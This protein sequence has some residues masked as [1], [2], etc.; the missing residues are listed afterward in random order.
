MLDPFRAVVRRCELCNLEVA[1][2]TIEMFASIPAC[3][4]CRAGK[5][6]RALE[7][8]ALAVSLERFARDP[9][10]SD[11]PTVARRCSMASSSPRT[12]TEALT[13]RGP[14]LPT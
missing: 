9:R 1:A 6:D 8:W 7:R 2:E 5:L 10:G 3:H 13:T 4:D 11:R 12:R 14:T